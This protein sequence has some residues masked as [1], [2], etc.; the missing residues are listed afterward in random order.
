MTNTEAARSLAACMLE[1]KVRLELRGM[2]EVG[3]RASNSP[4]GASSS[5]NPHPWV[6]IDTLSNPVAP[7]HSGMRGGLHRKFVQRAVTSEM[8]GLPA[9]E[10]S[11]HL[12]GSLIDYP[13]GR[14]PGKLLRGRLPARC[15]PTSTRLLALLIG[16]LHH[17]P[18]DSHLPYQIENFVRLVLPMTFH[19]EL[20]LDLDLKLG[21]V[22]AYHK[23]LADDRC[24][25]SFE[26]P[27]RIT[28]NVFST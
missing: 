19:V 2:T 12:G 26:C 20:T 11:N 6:A 1:L 18:F 7:P 22:Q 17:A 5:S 24:G 27:T 10:T 21:R 4:Q 23:R 14:F 15:R 9:F 8:T 25:T 28:E 16:Q 3:A 13:A